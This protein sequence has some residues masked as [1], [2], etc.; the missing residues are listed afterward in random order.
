M[1]STPVIS[2]LS[3]RALYNF[4]ASAT[5]ELSF[6]KGDIIEVYMCLES[7]WWDGVLD[8]VRGWFPSTWCEVVAFPENTMP[9]A[10]L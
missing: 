8:D 2:L 3:V 9:R 1:E 4:N 6:R 5:N 10:R 7:G